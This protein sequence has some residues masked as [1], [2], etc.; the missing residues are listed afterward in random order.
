MRHVS[1]LYGPGGAPLW[2]LRM[3][4]VSGSIAVV[5]TAWALYCCQVRSETTFLEV[6][7]AVWVLVPP[8]WFAIE[9]FY[10]FRRFN[11]V[12]DLEAFKYGQDTAAKGW[13]AVVAVLSA[14]L[15][16]GS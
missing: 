16:L 6:M 10:V 5:A 14:V 1:H 8:A 11:N 15:H 12:A 4:Q 3:L 9:Y 7:W 13:L 2:I